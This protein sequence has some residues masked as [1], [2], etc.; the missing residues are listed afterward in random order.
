MV[1]LIEDRRLVARPNKVQEAAVSPHSLYGVAVELFSEGEVERHALPKLQAQRL[2]G[3]QQAAVGGEGAEGEMKLGIRL[4][5][6]AGDAMLS[7]RGHRI[8]RGLK[9]SQQSIV[10][11][12]HAQFDRETLQSPAETVDLPDILSCQLRNHRAPPGYGLDQPV[13]LEHA[14]RL[15]QWWTAD[16]ELLGEPLFD[17]AL[18]RSELPRKNEIAQLPY[19]LLDDGGRLELAGSGDLLGTL[20]LHG[21]H[22]HASKQRSG[23]HRRG[24]GGETP[25]R[26]AACSHD[27]RL[28]LT[29][30]RFGAQ[31][32]GLLSWARDDAGG[33]ERVDLRLRIAGLVADG[34]AVLTKQRRGESQPVTVAGQ[35]DHAAQQLHLSQRGVAD[36]L[37]HVQ[38]IGDGMLQRL[39]DVEHGTARNAK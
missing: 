15:P 32:F 26:I 33:E 36:L 7:R 34:P 22:G 29:P 38:G 6:L 19:Q 3:L 14:E 20:E 30:V 21:C 25:R 27:I 17:Q 23:V 24:A 8:E 18:S 16:A 35:L 13:P 1:H 37:D 2:V 39:A 10:G 28:I 9:R 4:D 5:Q 31:I 12:R 11:H